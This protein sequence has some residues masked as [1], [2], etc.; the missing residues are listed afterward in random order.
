MSLRGTAGAFNLRVG[1]DKDAQAIKMLQHAAPWSLWIFGLPIAALA[2]RL[3]RRF[4]GHH[5]LLEVGMAA[6]TVVLTALVYKVTSARGM[7]RIHHVVNMFAV[8]GWLT[9]VTWSGPNGALGIVYLVGGLTG[10]TAWNVRYTKHIDRVMDAIPTSTKAARSRPPIV[11]VGYVVRALAS[12][13]PV[14]RTAM[15][16]AGNVVPA[17]KRPWAPAGELTAGRTPAS[18]TAVNTDGTVDKVLS[19]VVLKGKAVGTDP[20]PVWERIARNWK[21][22][23][24]QRQA[25]RELNGA[26]LVPLALTPTRIKSKVVLARGHHLPK[27]VEDAREHLAVMN[28]LPLSQVQVLA[29]GGL[30]GEVLVDWIIYDTLS[31]TLEW[32]GIDGQWRGIT[33]APLVFGQRE[34]GSLM[35][36]HQPAIPDKGVNLSHLGMEGMN[37]S[38][39]SNV[40]RLAIAQGV[41]IFD[42]VDWVMDPMKATQTIGCVM[43]ALD[44]MAPTSKEAVEL[45]EF[46]V[47]L[48]TARAEYLGNN[49]YDEWVPGCGL[50]FQRVY[51][52][53]G[54]LTADLLGSEMENVGNLARSTGVALIA[55]FQRMHSANVPTGLRAVFSETMS[56]GCRGAGDAFLLPDELSAAGADPSVWKSKKPGMLYW[57]SRMEDV[58]QWIIPGRTFRASEKVA[59]EVCDTYGDEKHRRVRDEFPDWVELI[60]KLDSN[61]VYRNR[62]TGPAKRASIL[63]ARAKRDGRK[64]R[65]HRPADAPENRTEHAPETEDEPMIENTDDNPQPPEADVHTDPAYLEGLRKPTPTV[66]QMQK[67]VI[68]M[69]GDPAFL[70]DAKDESLDSQEIPIPHPDM[71][72]HFGQPPMPERPHGKAKSLAH[73]IAYLAEKGPGYRFQ[74]HEVAGDCIEITGKSMSWYRTI[75]TTEIPAM[76]L[77]EWDPEK[78]VHRVAKDIRNEDTRRR[79][80]EQLSRIPVDA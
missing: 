70:E 42:V 63:E 56:F 45:I 35:T 36:W 71:V 59:A 27:M 25:G 38:G 52:E 60:R 20:K 40:A 10:C 24:T 57:A 53:E 28:G 43:A 17:L 75:L 49:G 78:G 14:V 48:V 51:L 4:W 37:G 67:E 30:H 69:G 74:P 68:A 22:F 58:E 21:V 13:A 26:R 62:T 7:D 76:G 33:D 34:D 9:A 15:E 64:E 5:T 32:Q 79:V 72:L 3:A 66:D 46:V 55:S 77:T 31:S 80:A 6:G 73:L 47:E 8:M 61:G 1:T 11:D 16:G 39:K 18:G 19:G 23:T 50:P 54:N 44:W 2:L 12:R 29:S 41:R 65:A